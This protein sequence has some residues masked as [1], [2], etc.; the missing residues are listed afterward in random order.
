MA[1]VRT[2]LETSFSHVNYGTGNKTVGCFIGLFHRDM[3]EGQ[4][5]ESF[6]SLQQTAAAKVN[7]VYFR[8]VFKG[9]ESFMVQPCLN[10]RCPHDSIKRCIFPV[11]GSSQAAQFFPLELN[12]AVGVRPIP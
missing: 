7:L 1:T 12:V 8:V 2:N 10:K 3:S 6:S 11:G 4:E 9:L 5:A